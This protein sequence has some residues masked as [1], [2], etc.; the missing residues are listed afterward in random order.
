VRES[1]SVYIEDQDDPGEGDLIFEVESSTDL[2]T[3]SPALDLTLQISLLDDDS[4]EEEVVA[5]VPLATDTA[6][7]PGQFQPVEYLRLIVTLQTLP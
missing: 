4:G 5:S 1:D 2:V 3:W 7:S 6:P